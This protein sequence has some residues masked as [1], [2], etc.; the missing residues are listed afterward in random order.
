MNKSSLL[1]FAAIATLVWTGSS[2]FASADELAPAD[3]KFLSGYEK[4]RVALVADD[5]SS[6]KAA[7]TTLGESG[8]ALG[9]SPSLKEARAAF[10]KLSENAKKLAKGQS[11][12]YVVHCSML[13]KDWVQ[14]STNI[15]NPYAGK[16]M[17]ECGEVVK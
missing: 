12:Y 9:A 15:G 11:G 4:V 3:K 17:A 5:L 1:S 14:T 7:A 6:A 8:S 2:S 10:D 16:E 13:K